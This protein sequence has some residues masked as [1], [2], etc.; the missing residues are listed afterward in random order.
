MLCA[1]E[2]IDN[3]FGF[4][5]GLNI[6]FTAFLRDV[7]RGT[8]V[9]GF[10]CHLIIEIFIRSIPEKNIVLPNDT[11]GQ[12][13]KIELVIENNSRDLQLYN[14]NFLI[15]IGCAKAELCNFLSLSL[16]KFKMELWSYKFHLV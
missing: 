7:A 11:F 15:L 8:G 16:R 1:F 4:C 13:I 12:E 3:L 10:L 14:D 5:F 6:A 2:E 9:L